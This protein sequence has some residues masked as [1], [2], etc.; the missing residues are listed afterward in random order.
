MRNAIRFLFLGFLAALAMGCAVADTGAFGRLSDEVGGLRKDVNTLK[1]T[2][3]ASPAGMQEIPGLRR[4]VADLGNDSDRLRSDQLAM[5]SR[6]DE[7]QAEMERTVREN[8]RMSDR[9]QELE[10]RII[11]MES[12][13]QAGADSR[14]P[15]D[16]A[17][18]SLNVG[19]DE[20]KSPEEMYEYAVGQVRAGSPKKGR[21]VIT[22]FAA[23]YPDHKLLPN[24]LYWKGESYYSEKDYENAILSFQ[25]VVDKYP[26]ADK[27]SDAIYKQG[28]SFMSLKDGKNAKILFNLVVTKYP[29]SSAAALAKKQL[30]Q[31]K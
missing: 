20:W 28:L 6:L 9:V 14:L 5:N 19:S 15:P 26:D 31:I 8:R 22:A 4:T 1:A 2:S 21:E 16:A 13:R 30:S 27:A 29:N 25:D 12:G 24:A 11:A 18:G 3:Y 7:I 23:Q 10:K 17:S